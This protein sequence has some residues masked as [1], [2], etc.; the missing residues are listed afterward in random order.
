MCAGLERMFHPQRLQRNAGGVKAG[1]VVAYHIIWWAYAHHFVKQQWWGRRCVGYSVFT[2]STI[3]SRH[4]SKKKD[5]SLCVSC[6]MVTKTL[7]VSNI[8]I[9]LFWIPSLLKRKGGRQYHFVS[10][11]SLSARFGKNRVT[12]S[13]LQHLRLHSSHSSGRGSNS[14]P[15]PHAVIALPYRSHP[16]LFLKIK[17][18]RT[19]TSRPGC[20]NQTTTFTHGG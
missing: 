3:S 7:Q 20:W 13:I 8:A 10:K 14:R 1:I 4:R 18:H 19:A 11:S 16:G 9:R 2:P 12:S 17:V 6:R 5:G 15:F